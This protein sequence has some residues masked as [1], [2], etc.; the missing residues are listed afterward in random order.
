MI[1]CS[2]AQIYSYFNGYGSY[3]TI[4]SVERFFEVLKKQDNQQKYGVYL[5]DFE[6]NTLNK[7]IHII[8]TSDEKIIKII[9]WDNYDEKSDIFS[10]L[11]KYGVITHLHNYRKTGLFTD[12]DYSCDITFDATNVN[13]TIPKIYLDDNSNTDVDDDTMEIKLNRAYTSKLDNYEYPIYMFEDGSYLCITYSTN[14]RTYG[15]NIYTTEAF[16]TQGFEESESAD[17]IF[18]DID[19]KMFSF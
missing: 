16:V 12:S 13:T 18:E 11:K 4:H 9:E 2:P 14:C 3:D 19:P 10:Y 5:S 7:F 1:G 8:S 17:D 6:I 15:L